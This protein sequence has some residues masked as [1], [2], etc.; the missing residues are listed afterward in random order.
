MA[1]NINASYCLRIW[2]NDISTEGTIIMNKDATWDPFQ[3]GIP[4]GW[5][6]ETV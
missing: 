4:N 2:A 6:I 1:T 3:N 5:T